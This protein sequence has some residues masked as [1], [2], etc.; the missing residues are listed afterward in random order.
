[1][2][3]L[4]RTYKVI[5]FTCLSQIS[6]AQ[7]HS[8][9]WF[10]G[11][12][13]IPS[14]KN[15]LFDTELQY[16]RQNGLNNTNMFDKNLLFAIRSWVHYKYNNRIKLSLSPFAYFSNYRIIRQEGDELVKPTSEIRISGAVELQND[17]LKQ[18]FLV[19]RTAIEYRN[20]DSDQAPVVRLRSRLGLRYDLNEKWKSGIYDE[21]IINA[22]GVPL[23]H[24]FD[25]NRIGLF[26]KYNV[27]KN[28]DIELSYLYIFR[29]PIKSMDPLREN[30]FFL[31]LSYQLGPHTK[32]F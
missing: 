8:N 22:A 21:L 20:F 6:Y 17:L 4:H 2:T 19:S 10:R 29:L 18:L 25:H 26:L 5:V 16:R 24:V 32:Y 13:R 12:F 7:I 28:L 23:E 14:G 27:F 9:S 30:N 1:M 3:S 31:H 15:I 11:S